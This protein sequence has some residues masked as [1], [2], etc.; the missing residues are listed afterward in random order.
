MSA[1]LA[2]KKRYSMPYELGHTQALRMDGHSAG[3]LD[4]RLEG[5][6]ESTT[7]LWT[8]ALWVFI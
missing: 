3:F 1:S 6:E 8:P 5:M 2:L 4:W 7:R